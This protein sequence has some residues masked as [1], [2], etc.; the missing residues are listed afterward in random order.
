MQPRS[1]RVTFQI[2]DWPNGMAGDIGATLGHG[3]LRGNH[4]EEPQFY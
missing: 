2:G 4:L 3:S 1:Y